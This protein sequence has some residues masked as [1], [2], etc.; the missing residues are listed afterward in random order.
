MNT[1]L[2]TIDG[3]SASLAELRRV[4]IDALVKALG[5]IGMARFLRQFD[6]GH[7][8]Y[9][10]ERHLALGNPTVDELLQELDDRRG[11]PVSK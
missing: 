10:A 1:R 9:T 2:E 3:G 5:P 7:G 8:D 4:G 11:N 6:F